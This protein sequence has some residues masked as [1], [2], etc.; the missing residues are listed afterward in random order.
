M[1]QLCTLYCNQNAESVL[2]VVLVGFCLC[3]E[4][5]YSNSN[6]SFDSKSSFPLIQLFFSCLD[7]LAFHCECSCVTENIVN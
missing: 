1:I 6:S 5:V 7:F 2:A 4:F 3:P